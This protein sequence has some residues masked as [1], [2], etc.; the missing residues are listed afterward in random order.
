MTL[1]SYHLITSF[2]LSHRDGDLD[3]CDKALKNELHHY[4][5]GVWFLFFKG[6]LEFM[7]ANIENSIQW[8]EK[9]WKSQ[10]VWPQFHH[11]C[12]WELM[13]AH[14]CQQDWDSA[15]FYARSLAEQSNWSRTIY[16]YQQAVLMI[17]KQQQIEKDQPQKA[18]SAAD[19][20]KISS[21]MTQVPTYKQRIAGKSL[22]MEKFVVKKSERYFSQN[23]TLVLPIF[24]LMF[25]WNLFRIIG[26]RS[27]LIV[28]VY[29]IIE[30][31]EKTLNQT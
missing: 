26:K 30:A 5:E 29:K 10:N 4:P 15:L 31:E 21:L 24:E 17:M 28:N 19:L 12:F 27:D 3:W 23:K 22:P 25:V 7:K 13:W 8:Y 11:L 20:E 2:V 14:C 1:L 6:R 16:L 9:S 18:S